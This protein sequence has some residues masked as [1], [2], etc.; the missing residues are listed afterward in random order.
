MKNLTRSTAVLGA[1]GMVAAG[2][3]ATAAPASANHTF[4]IKVTEVQ[5]DYDDDFTGD[6]EVGD[7]FSFTSNLRQDGK[8]VGKD[9]GR[10]VFKKFYGPENYPTGARVRC[11]VTVHFFTKGT[12]RVAGTTR[13]DFD[14][15]HAS[16]TIPV[17][18]GTGDYRG[19]GGTVRVNEVS[20][21]KSR[22]TFRLTGV[23]H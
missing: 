17:T 22:L 15:D 1:A 6:P 23:D 4:V 2:L 16:F 5:T 9:T 21:T 3:V 11:V 12:I 18:G 10:C 13:F 7:S 8:R 14:D 20:D 19:V